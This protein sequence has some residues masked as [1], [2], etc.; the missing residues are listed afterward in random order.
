ML[1][2]V[3]QLRERKSPSRQMAR[4]RETQLVCLEP[5]T[6]SLVWWCALYHGKWGSEKAIPSRG[7]TFGFHSGFT[8]LQKFPLLLLVKELRDFHL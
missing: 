6:D 2:Q 8:W 5:R 7:G 1:F 4:G 3:A